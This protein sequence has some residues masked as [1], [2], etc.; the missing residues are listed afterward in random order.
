MSLAVHRAELE[1]Q[2]VTCCG[3]FTDETFTPKGTDKPVTYQVLHLTR[4]ET[5]AGAFP[6]AAGATESAPEPEPDLSDLPEQW[7]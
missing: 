2:R 6:Q 7:R 5:P 1:G 4:I 3:S